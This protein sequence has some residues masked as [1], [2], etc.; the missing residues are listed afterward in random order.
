MAFYLYKLVWP[1]RLGVDYGRTPREILA[2]GWA[3]LAALVPLAMA[4]VLWAKRQTI[5][6]VVAGASVVV[7]GMLPVLGLVRFDFQIY[8]TVADH[9]LYLPMLGVAMF[10]AALTRV[11]TFR[12][13]LL[14]LLPLLAARTW[15][16]ATT[17]KDSVSLFTHAL[18][19]N[20]R[21]WMSHDNLAGACLRLGKPDDAKRHCL[22]AIAIKPDVA[23]VYDQLALCLEIEGK[24]SEAMEAYRIAI[25]LQHDDGSAWSGL[26]DLLMK[27]GD[28]AGA[29]DAYAHAVGA[30]PDDPDLMVNLASTLAEDEQLARAIEMYQ[31]ALRI[32]PNSPEAR[33]G[34][35]RA[36][37]ALRNKER[38]PVP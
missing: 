38:L 15:L 36:A 33:A 3:Y 7:L 25:K 19:V 23:N 30:R 13:V 8:S 26:G 1:L 35:N 37:E 14:I 17:W 16:Q 27:Q 28:R 32:K 34:L 4:I 18:Q 21:S 5:P 6:F 22:S 9:Y 20:P 12:V 10:V 11:K 29:I 31:N 24:T 2:S